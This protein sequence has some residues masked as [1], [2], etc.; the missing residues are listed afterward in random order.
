MEMLTDLDSRSLA[1]LDMLR[2][3]ENLGSSYPLT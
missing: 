1:V 3:V 2:M